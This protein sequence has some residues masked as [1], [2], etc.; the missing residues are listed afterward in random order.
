MSSVGLLEN[1]DDTK[2]YKVGPSGD[3][4]VKKKALFHKKTKKL[5]C[6]CQMFEWEGIPCMHLLAYFFVKRF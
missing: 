2:I 5:I 3:L 6:A 1:N 4:H